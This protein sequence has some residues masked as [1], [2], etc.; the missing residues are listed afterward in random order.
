MMRRLLAA[1][2]LTALDQRIKAATVSGTLTSYRSYAFRIETTCGSQLPVGMLTLG[3]LADVGCLIAPRPVCFE[4]GKADCLVEVAHGKSL[5]AAAIHP[6]G[7]SFVTAAGTSIKS[8]NAENGE[9]LDEWTTASPITAL[10]FS[11]E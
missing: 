5:V 10:L 6:D 4:V 7:K 11:P 9:L 1:L 3:D 8:W 2:F